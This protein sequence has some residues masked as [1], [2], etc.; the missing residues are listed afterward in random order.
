MAPLER[1]GWIAGTVWDLNSTVHILIVVSV[2]LYEM[3]V[4]GKN[5]RKLRID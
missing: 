3:L 2:V 4:D 1:C 5:F